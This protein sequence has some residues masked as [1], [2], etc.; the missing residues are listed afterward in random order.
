MKKTS[1]SRKNKIFLVVLVTLIIAIICYVIAGIVIYNTPKQHTLSAISIYNIN[2][3]VDENFERND[4]DEEQARKTTITEKEFIEYLEKLQEQGKLEK[5]EV[6]ETSIG[7]YLV[8][9]GYFLCRFDLP[10][11]YQGASSNSNTNRSNDTISAT[12]NEISLSVLSAQP[13]DDISS[14]VFDNSAS[15]IENANLGYEFT[16]NID[17]ANVTLEFMKTLSKYRVIIWNG[18]GGCSDDR[19][20]YSFQIGETWTNENYEK[21]RE[22]ENAGRVVRYMEGGVGITPKFF[23]DYYEDDAFNDT[24]IYLGSCHLGE[25]SSTFAE[26]FIKKG[27]EAV[28]AYKNTVFEKYNQK[29]CETVFNELIKQDGDTGSTK[30]VAEALETAKNQNGEKDPSRSKWYDLVLYPVFQDYMPKAKRAELVLTENDNNSFR[31]VDNTT[32]EV[33]TEVETK[34][35]TDY[36]KIYTDYVSDKII[37]DIGVCNDFEITLD[38]I[39]EN[40]IYEHIDNSKGLSSV[41]ID[42]FNNDKIPEM[43]TVSALGK[44]NGF[45]KIRVKLYCIENNEVVKKGVV[46]ETDKYDNADEQLYVY[47]VKNDSNTFLCLSD[48]FWYGG[49]SSG[50]I[51]AQYFKAFSVDKNNKLSAKADLTFGYNRGNVTYQINGKEYVVANDGEYNDNISSVK[52]KLNDLFSDIGLS[53]FKGAGIETANWMGFPKSNNSKVFKCGTKIVSDYT[54]KAYLK[55]YTGFSKKHKTTKP[56]I[57]KNITKKSKE[58]KVTTTKETTSSSLKDILLKYYWIGDSE[59]LAPPNKNIYEFTSDKVVYHYEGDISQDKSTWIKHSEKIT[60][61]IENNTL[62]IDF[63]DYNFDVDLKYVKAKNYFNKVSGYCFYQTDFVSDGSP[64]E[65]MYLLK[66]KLK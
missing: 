24:L 61:E 6:G 59:Q 14:D 20:S 1:L 23:E 41:C 37:A 31:L 66:G 5:Y 47:T 10:N 19:G 7:V 8:D 3:L 34:E 52:N 27:A 45:V 33:T 32:K 22:E 43:I 49:S 60:Y 54:Y 26:T 55:D 48:Q 4:E 29:M 2:S 50:S 15:L 30:T 38:S 25:G 39:A 56:A 36:E 40:T 35:N 18:H 58:D 9:Y 53:E 62:K 11:G 46:Y 44:D 28:L 12:T 21:Y 63:V 57:E 17:S 64:M 42:D 16:D 51:Y 65:A 13:C